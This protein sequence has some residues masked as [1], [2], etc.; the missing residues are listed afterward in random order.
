MP[1]LVGD[2]ETA[3]ATEETHILA[4]YSCIIHEKWPSYNGRLG[5]CVTT[6]GGTTCLVVCLGCSGLLL[7]TM[8]NIYFGTF[9]SLML[10]CLF[11]WRP[12]AAL[13]GWQ[14]VHGPPMLRSSASSSSAG[15][16][17]SSAVSALFQRHKRGATSVNITNQ[18]KKSYLL[19]NESVCPYKVFSEGQQ[20]HKKSICFRTTDSDFRCDQRE[21][22]EYKSG[23]SLLANVLRNSSVLLQWQPPAPYPPDLRGFLINC[24]WNGTFT[25]FQCDSVQLGVNCRDYLLTNVHDNVRYRICLQTLFSNRTSM[26]E[27]VD[28]SVEPV[29]MQDIV[30]AMTAVGGSI[31][32]MLVI[33]CLLVAYITENLM[34]PAFMHPSTKRGPWYFH[35]CR[36]L[37]KDTSYLIDRNPRSAVSNDNDYKMGTTSLWS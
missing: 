29:G 33:I 22:I 20:D 15:L 3:A 7:V 31:C 21:C 11:E 37:W 23:R 36:C 25:R 1:Q 18:S 13:G 32:V 27:C 24:S 8:I 34:H 12:T 19:L 6:T 30:I 16:E 2:G 26:E 35:F 4:I 17:P 5:P 9:Q 10:L 14:R 28:F